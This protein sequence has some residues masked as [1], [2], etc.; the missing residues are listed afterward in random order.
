MMAADYKQKGR[1]GRNN[2][3]YEKKEAG[4][5]WTEKNRSQGDQPFFLTDILDAVMKQR[6]IQAD[7][8][9][10]AYEEKKVSGLI[11]IAWSR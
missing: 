1:K 8:S 9:E 11:P 2:G 3:T 10:N 5:N 4:Q 6:S 7:Y